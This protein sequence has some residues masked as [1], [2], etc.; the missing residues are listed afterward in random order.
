[1]SDKGTPPPTDAPAVQFLRLIRRRLEAV[2]T[3]VG[4][5]TTL[6]EKMASGLLAGGDF[7]APFL[8]YWHSESGGRAGGLMGMNRHHGLRGA[9]DLALFTLPQSPTWDPKQ[10][11]LLQDLLNGPGKLFVIGRPEELRGAAA[12]RRFAG[13]TGGAEPD[14][15]FYAYDRF[16]PLA[17]AVPFEQLVRGWIATGEMV[18]ACTRAGRM[19]IIWMSVWF[20]GARVRNAALVEESNLREPFGTPMFHANRYIPPLPPDDVARRFLRI[21]ESNRAKLLEQSDRLAKA[22][23]WMARA[24]RAGRRVRI[25]AVGHS[26]PHVLELT[27]NPHV[28]DF[29]GS[30]YPLEWGWSNSDVCRATPKDF[31]EGDVLLHLGYGPVSTEDVQGILARGIRLIHTSPYGRP[32]GLKDHKNF[33]WFDLPWP[34]GDASVDVPGYSVRILPMSSTCHAMALPAILCEIAERMGW[35]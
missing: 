14:Q 23:R 4:H 13:F 27:D 21:V 5:L 6:G 17:S 28:T 32:A 2:S 9:D 3:D 35:T 19:P 10:D 29:S 26:Y 15:G 30:G 16:R 20:E 24:K 12:K 34:P 11:K 25:V 8:S 31:G 18:A 33:L 1:M 7:C 22:G